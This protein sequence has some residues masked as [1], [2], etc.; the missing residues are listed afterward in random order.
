MESVTTA[1][2]SKPT[3]RIKV[4]DVLILLVFAIVIIVLVKTLT[5]KLSLQ[6]EVSSAKITT[7]RVV[8]DMQKQN[9]TDIY[10][11]GNK[12]FQTSHS[13]AQLQNLTVAAK[14]YVQ[15]T[16]TDVRRTV[17]NDKYG[18]KVAVIY[19]FNNKKPF[20]VGVTVNKLKGADKWSLIGLSGNANEA[21]LIN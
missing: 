1:K 6:H 7:S 14:S 8:N 13:T 21:E 5:N 18:Q 19:K 2:P 10:N 3:R 4:T 20:Y 9:A 17:T 16:P 12:T 15:G 11:L